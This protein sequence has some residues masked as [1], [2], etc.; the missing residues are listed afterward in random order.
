MDGNEEREAT[1]CTGTRQGSAITKEEPGN[2]TPTQDIS[3]ILT[4]LNFIDT[5]ERGGKP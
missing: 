5:K 2:L 1:T 3:L 4:K